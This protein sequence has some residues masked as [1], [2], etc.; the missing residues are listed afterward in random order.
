M[1]CGRKRGGREEEE[2]G[3]GGGGS[4]RGHI[5]TYICIYIHISYS[6]P[7]HFIAGYSFLPS[8][9]PKVIFSITN[10]LL[11]VPIAN[12]KFFK[13]SHAHKRDQCKRH[14]PLKLL[15]LVLGMAVE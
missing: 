7:C 3:G 10:T 6:C 12:D 2:G 1:I 8:S 4:L 14:L 15:A 13:F 5:Y 9:L 11:V